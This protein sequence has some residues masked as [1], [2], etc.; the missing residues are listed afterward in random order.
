MGVKDYNMARPPKPTALKLVAG[1]P[2]KR[3]L[4]RSEPDPEYL[5][6]LTAPGYLLP[7]AAVVWDE[8]VPHL[9]QAKLLTNV[10]VP[11]LAMGCTAIAQYREAV[12][13]AGDDLVKSKVIEGETGESIETGEHVNPWLVV[14][15]MSSKQAMAVLQQFGMSP[16]SRSRVAVNPQGDLFGNGK[17]GTDYFS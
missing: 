12:R 1:N 17:T 16:A 11:M 8:I 15:S 13:R 7:K 2:G 6:D 5:I 10:D 4:N 14:Q 9:R 3:A